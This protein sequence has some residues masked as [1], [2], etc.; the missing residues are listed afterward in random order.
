MD[1]IERVQSFKRGETGGAPSSP[2]PSSNTKHSS[3]ISKAPP[4]LPKSVLAKARE[5]ALKNNNIKN[6]NKNENDD[7]NNDKGDDDNKNTK[8]LD[9]MDSAG[10]V[11]ENLPVS[12]SPST[13]PARDRIQSSTTRR[14][15]AKKRIIGSGGV[16]MFN[17]GIGALGKGGLKKV[18]GVRERKEEVRRSFFERPQLNKVNRPSAKN[19][20]QEQKK[21]ARGG[22]RMSVTKEGEEEEEEE[23]RTSTIVGLNNVVGGDHDWEERFDEE[24]DA[25]YYFNKITHESSWEK[26]EKFVPHPSREKEE[27]KANDDEKGF[28]WEQRWEPTHKLHYYF[29][30]TTGESVWE[31]PQ[32]GFKPLEGSGEEGGEGKKEGGGEQGGGTEGPV[33][34]TENKDAAG[35]AAGAEQFVWEQRWEPTHN[36][37]YYFNTVSGESVWEPPQEGF[38]PLA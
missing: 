30:L 16:A 31:P 22:P 3:S 34:N 1:G 14:D 33:E 13:I 2:P 12:G 24:S 7:G 5:T 25:Y 15:E 29:N 17:P 36:L 27:A 20:V 38:K 23:R 28:V 18:E 4:V 19:L 26:P 35:S 37:H 32:E 9:R 11:S 21:V 8:N 6:S 10:S